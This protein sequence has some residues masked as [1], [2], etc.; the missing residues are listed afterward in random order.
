[1]VKA[2]LGPVWENY[3]LKSTEV[4]FTAANGTPYALGN[5]VRHRCGIFLYLLP[6]LRSVRTKG[7]ADRGSDRDATV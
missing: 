2:N 6:F 1:M 4:D 3:C 5:S 7:Q